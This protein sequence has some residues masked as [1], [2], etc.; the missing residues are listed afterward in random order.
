MNQRIKYFQLRLTQAEAEHIR[1]K[2]TSYS[3]VSHYIRSAIAEYSHVDAKQRLELINDLGA[4]YRKY[5]NE[6][7][8]I[9]S[10]L[11]QSVK[12]A[13]ELSVAGLL[14]PSYVQEVLIPQIQETQRT[15]NE[16]KRGL[17]AVTQ[18]AIKSK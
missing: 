4:F 15:L 16:I 3:S 17:D 13:N 5:Q 2:A 10:N 18:K 14:A 9:G 6:L 8:W 12:R 7:S 11:N 1:E